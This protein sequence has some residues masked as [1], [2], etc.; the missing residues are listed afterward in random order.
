MEL[1]NYLIIGILAV[2]I[3]F[4]I[5]F[6]IC[7]EVLLVEVLY[8]A[9]KKSLSNKVKNNIG[10]IKNNI[11]SRGNLFDKTE[12][13]CI[14]LM[15]SL[16]LMHILTNKECAK[17]EK[18][19]KNFTNRSFNIPINCPFNSYCNFTQIS[20]QNYSILLNRPNKTI[21]KSTN[22]IYSLSF[23]HFHLL[24]FLFYGKK[25]QPHTGHPFPA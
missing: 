23:Y 10:I 18:Q 20:L 8:V 2:L 17:N 19:H 1:L 6:I 15:I 4:N 13:N 24:K 12:K 11:E 7:L 14:N 16:I 21:I 9:Y 3:G 5:K 22:S 25:E